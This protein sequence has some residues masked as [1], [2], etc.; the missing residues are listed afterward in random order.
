MRNHL[1]RLI[2]LLIALPT[3]FSGLCPAQ[4]APPASPSKPTAARDSSIAIVVDTSDAAKKHFDD[5]KSAIWTFLKSFE[6]EDE[7]CLFSA[8]GQPRILEDFTTDTSVLKDR[9]KKLKANGRLA[10]PET[11]R[12]AAEHLR[13]DSP[14]DH[15]AVIVFVA[16]QEQ[17]DQAPINAPSG[18][19]QS[20]RVPVYVIAVPG[21][22][23]HMQ[24]ALQQ[25]ATASGG[26]AFFPRSRGQ[27]KEVSEQI[28]HRLAGAGGASGNASAPVTDAKTAR[29]QKSL[30]PYDQLTVRGIPMAGD[31]N[32]SESTGGENLLLQKVLVSRLQKAK[33]FPEVVDGTGTPPPSAQ[34][35]TDGK[36]GKKLDLLATIIEYRRGNRTQRQFM[37]F[38]GG[39]KFK[40]QVLL[41]DSATRKP[42]MTL[43]EEG[44]SASG[45]FGGSQELVQTKAMLELVDKIVDDLRHA[46]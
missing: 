33:V 7:L 24:E 25:L 3:G 45:L 37:G 32:T 38:R 26:A 29:K 43:N 31:D 21:S 28:A 17:R 27:L 14:T 22:D 19:A 16:A 5:M 12:T 46:R 23:W 30:A 39:A 42:V 1:L 40:V 13:A 44:S 15:A 10:L 6:G 9:V 34:P 35:E 8:G 2:L 18:D 20:L 41:V 11:T 36:P 4:D